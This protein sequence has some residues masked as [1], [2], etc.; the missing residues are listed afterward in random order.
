[1]PLNI[2]IQ[3]IL[4]HMLN[5]AILF[6][7]LYFLLYKPV[8]RFMDNRN[9]Y[10]DELEEKTNTTLSEAEKTK[11]EY[12]EKLTALKAEEKRIKAEAVNEAQIKA[13]KIVSDAQTKAADIIAKSKQRAAKEKD[14]MIKSANKEIRHIAEEAAQKL[15]IDGE[16]AY[17]TFLNAFGN[18]EN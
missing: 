2:D 8:R 18:G 12:E 3:Q 7:A 16:D 15:V 13:E 17:E 5:F 9:K 11:Q 6:A 4:L 14:S 1:M 10:Y